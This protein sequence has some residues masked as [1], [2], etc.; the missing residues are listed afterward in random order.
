[1]GTIPAFFDSDPRS[2]GIQGLTMA[3]L[4][5]AAGVVKLRLFRMGVPFVLVAP[6]ALKKFATGNGN[7]SKD[8]MVAACKAA[9]GVPANDDEADAFWLRRYGLEHG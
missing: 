2:G 7:A 5:E 3:K 9:G 1:M 4:G 6:K 8:E